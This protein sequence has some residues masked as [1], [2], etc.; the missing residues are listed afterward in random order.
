MPPRS[1]EES[2]RQRAGRTPDLIQSHLRLYPGNSGGPLVN[3]RGQ[4][5]GINNMVGG[6]LAFAIPSR[7]VQQFVAT[8]ASANARP[9]LGVQVLDVELPDALRARVGTTAPSAALI[10][11]VEDESP[12]EVAG[13]LPGD[14]V[15]GVD[16]R[17]IASSGDLLLALG[18]DA[19]ESAIH[20]TIIR[21][22]ARRELRVM[23]R[24][25][26]TAAA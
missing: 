20:L 22:G 7:I 21:A 24:Q 14:I 17:A 2:P 15:I 13:L 5:V 11:A 12:A 9:R 23:P 19:G 4:V 10:A 26:E 3:A 6:G 25:V 18:R 16:G 1:S 8:G